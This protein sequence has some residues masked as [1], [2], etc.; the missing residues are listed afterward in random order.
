MLARIKRWME[1]CLEEPFFRAELMRAEILNE[2][3][4]L[5]TSLVESLNTNY[6]NL[7]TWSK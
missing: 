3:R 5:M 2:E 6:H 1:R 7:K 4:D